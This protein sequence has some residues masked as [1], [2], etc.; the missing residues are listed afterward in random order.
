M[1]KRVRTRNRDDYCEDCLPEH[2]REMIGKNRCQH[3]EVVFRA[4]ED[5]FMAG[6]R[7]EIL[8]AA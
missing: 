6:F 5:G 2:Q 3:P 1:T 8:E 4:D 7:S